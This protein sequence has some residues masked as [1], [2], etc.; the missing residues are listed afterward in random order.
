MTD[1][2]VPPGEVDAII[3]ARID[4]AMTAI[5]PLGADAVTF[6]D[7]ARAYTR[8]GKRIRAA[9]CIAGYEST[10]AAASSAAP[11][12]AAALEFFHAA[13]LAHDDIID[14][15]DT[16][17]G[18]PS[19]H[20]A[21][22]ALHDDARWAGD[23][24]HFGTSA[25][26][27]LGDLL[28]VCS[29]ELMVEAEQLVP[30]DAGRAARAEFRRMRLEVSAGQYLDLV[31]EVAWP[32]VPTPERAARAITIATAKSARYSVEA[33]LVL[34]ARLGGADDD[35]IERIRA[36]G[37]PLGLAF[38]LRD[39][40]LGVFG[41]EA[42]TGK[43][44]GDDL[45]EGKR[46]LLV[47]DTLARLDADAAAAFDQDLGDP[48][49]DDADVER[50]QGV[51]RASGGLDATER[52]IEDWLGTGLAAIDAAGLRP[53]STTLLRDLAHRTARRDL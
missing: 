52:R 2:S 39:D 46:T 51:I 11:T 35:D 14:R 49:L 50:L 45:R 31:E 8:G 24:A 17:R 27:L 12:A 5:A 28:L 29:D 30:P 7:R 43:P 1:S 4:E 21:F 48:D 33:P 26:L 3:A 15:S 38:Q 34:G 9:F 47:A 18:L 13:A 44:A 32:T 37:L 19:A 41:D 10:G 6:V 36:F 42:V 40:V 23:G 20:R 53:E 16:R 22:E 25:A